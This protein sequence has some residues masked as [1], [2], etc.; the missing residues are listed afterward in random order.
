MQQLL[1]I[2]AALVAWCTALASAEKAEAS[3]L[4]KVQQLLSDQAAKVSKEGDE[5]KR[6]YEE[7][8]SWCDGRSKELAFEIRTGESD[9]EGQQA[10]IDNDAATIASLGSRVEALVA[11]IATQEADLKAASEVR[12]KD[13]ADFSAEEKELTQ[14]IDML[15]RAISV[16]EREARKGAGALLQLQ[17]ASSM[18]EVLGTMVQASMFSAADADRLAALVQSSQ[19][20]EDD[21]DLTL[22]APAAAAYESK[23][24]SILQTLGD[25]QDKAEAQLGE[26]RSRETKNL[27]AFELLKQSLE[28]QTRL[29]KKDLA[30]AQRGIS[31]S[32]QSKSV[33]EGALAASSKELTS[34]KQGLQDLQHDCLARAS[35]YESETKSREEELKV[36]AEAKKIIDDSTGGAAASTY[37]LSQVSLLQLSQ[38]ARRTSSGSDLAS[39]VSV[40]HLLRGL[41]RKVHSSAL[42]Q[43]ASR[44]DSVVGRAL[45]RGTDPFAKVKGLIS[46]MVEKLE[47]EAQ[48]DAT[49][50]AFCDKEMQETGAKE[51]ARS[52]EAGKLSTKIEQMSARSGQLKEEVAALQSSLAALASSQAELD[53][54][55]QEQHAA[56][57]SSKADLESGLDGVKR[58][59]KVLRDYY[60]VGEKA[61]G[62]AG[63]GIIGLLEVVESDFSK[64]FAEVVSSEESEQASYAKQT[65]NNQLEKASKDKDVEYKNKEAADLDKS[66]ADAK[67]DLASA[68]QELS[69][70]EE[71]FEKLKEQ[72]VAKPEAYE[73]RKLRREQELAGL[74]EALQVLESDSSLLQTS[75]R[76]LLRG[77]NP[78][79]RA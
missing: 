60:G 36:I 21:E 28:D 64:G 18:V 25:L 5:A 3:P 6:L 9:V 4:E 41:A 73:D 34:D 78:H 57:V 59:L 61:A 2:A 20:S 44:V 72:C 32:G 70:V 47:A 42:A 55:R 45:E 69:A 33:A 71:Y 12:N 16:I 11:D 31:Q 74:K 76:R 14:V 68:E 17:G 24:G 66:A 46:Q 79:R 27:H 56:Y 54:L 38:G 1:A 29:S 53:K 23:S 13:A 52:T 77:I 62:G 39:Q 50:K 15:R 37:A 67:G 19:A 65:N 49:Q 30:E 58:A 51:E 40:V 43:L 75:S 8:S 7:Y 48:A 22:G 35:D 63:S 26:A 10:A